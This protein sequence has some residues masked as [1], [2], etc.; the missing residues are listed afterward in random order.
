MSELNIDISN[1]NLIEFNPY[2]SM[3]DRVVKDVLQMQK[4]GKR[5][6]LIGNQG[7][8]LIKD[9]GFEIIEKFREHGIEI[10]SI[11]GP[12]A[13]TA[14][15][16]TSGIFPEN[17]YF[18][19]FMPL[20]SKDRIAFLSNLKNRADCA[21]VIFESIFSSGYQSCLDIKEVFG[22]EARM[23][24]HIDMTRQTEKSFLSSISECINWIDTIINSES[25][26]TN[27]NESS[28]LVYV[29]DNWPTISQ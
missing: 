15:L 14:A 9:P 13:I 20:M 29:I 24:L 26:T 4:D 18:A 17:F 27:Y 16:S 5:I 6:M 8:P 28:G 19:G 10:T 21:I 25:F 11:P 7:T 22:P 2:I 1:K 3:P 23:S 12:S